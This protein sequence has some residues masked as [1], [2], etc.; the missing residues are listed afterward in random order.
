[1]VYGPY[2]LCAIN[3]GKNIT[4]FLKLVVIWMEYSWASTLN[5]PSADKTQVLE[6][7]SAGPQIIPERQKRGW[8]KKPDVRT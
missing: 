3:R 1:M 5:S 6:V 4:G 2:P 7:V 8:K